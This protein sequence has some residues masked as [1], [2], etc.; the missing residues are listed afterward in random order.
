MSFKILIV[1]FTVLGLFLL[2]APIVGLYGI[3]S[4]RYRM[5][6]IMVVTGALLLAVSAVCAGAWWG[7]G[8]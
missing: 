1:F 2:L 3:K 4:Q 5:Y 7:G 6:T 8:L